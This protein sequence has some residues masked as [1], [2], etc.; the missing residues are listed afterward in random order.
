MNTR[1]SESFLQELRNKAPIEDVISPYVSLKRNGRLYRGLCPFHNEK[2]PSFTVFTDTQSFY[3][4]GCGAGGD[5]INFI[6]KIENIEYT[7]AVKLLADR[8]GVQM[9]E[10][11]YDDTFS[12][13]RKKI[14]E[15]NR[16]AAR[17]YNSYL[18]S[19]KGKAGL[20]YLMGRGYTA[21]TIKKFG[22]GYAPDA[23]DELYNHLRGEGYTSGEIADSTL[24]KKNQRGVYDTFRN[25]VMVPIIDVRSNVIAF[26]GRVIGNESKWKYINS[27]DTPV[28]KKADELFGLNLAKNSGNRSLI[29]CEGYMDVITMHEAGF[30]NAVASCGTALTPDQVK[31]ASRYADEVILAYDSDAAGQKAVDKALAL[32]K[33]TNVKVRVIV[34]DEEG[35]PDD[36]IKKRGASK[37]SEMINGA[38][39][40]SEYRL[41]KLQKSFN[42]ENAQGKLDFMNKAV[43]V[44][45]D[46]PPIEQDI[47]I[48]RLSEELNIER[49]SIKA[50]VEDY[51]RRNRRSNRKKDFQNAVN[52]SIRNN[53]RAAVRSNSTSRELAAQERIISLLF[54]NPDYL[55]KLQRPNVEFF[56]DA[57]LKNIYNMMCNNI[58]N[59]IN[60]DIINLS[61][62]LSQEETARLSGILA[63][64]GESVNPVQEYKDCLALLESEYEKKNRKDVAGMSDEEFRSLFKNKNQQ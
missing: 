31:L 27:D 21:K 14:L 46:A 9:P 25:R 61:Q 56:T 50:Q 26:G 4:F 34:Y 38:L 13:R 37:F 36:I 23:W 19:E 18:M 16:E 51:K 28:Y 39:N 43:A 6:S 33:N 22:L 62:Y 47:Y 53:A 11:D 45:A 55:K 48:S 40:E 17:F 54:S 20:D 12:T 59:D 64:G 60:N 63:R 10:A 15:I 35:D 3:C 41:Y 52:E 32:F 57:E 44:L 49:N 42:I 5:I 58:D 8:Y 1:F 29:L 7:E 24:I 30:T 2:T